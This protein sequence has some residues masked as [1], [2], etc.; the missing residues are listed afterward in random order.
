MRELAIL[1]VQPEHLIWL[2]ATHESTR[3]GNLSFFRAS[4]LISSN[5][6]ESYIAERG[7]WGTG[8]LG[9][10]MAFDFD[11]YC[12]NPSHEGLSQS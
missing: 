3:V 10:W 6:I 7:C 5:V 11:P 12:H 1:L 8:K 4:P 9:Q 2:T